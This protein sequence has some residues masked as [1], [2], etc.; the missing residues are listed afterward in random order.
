MLKDLG[1]R[2]GTFVDGQRI[3]TAAVE[4]RQ[5]RRTRIRSYIFGIGLTW[6]RD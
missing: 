1:S 4:G 6:S 3:T 5:E 2:N